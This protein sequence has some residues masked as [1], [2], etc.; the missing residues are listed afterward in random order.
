MPVVRL[1]DPRGALTLAQK[2]QLAASRRAEIAAA[3]GRADP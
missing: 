1:S 2:R 3:I